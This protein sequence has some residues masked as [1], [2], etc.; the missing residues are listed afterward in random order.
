MV[1]IAVWQIFQCSPPQRESA[2]EGR[3][4][5]SD[6]LPIFLCRTSLPENRRKILRQELTDLAI[7]ATIP[8]SFVTQRYLL[9]LKIRKETLIE[10]WWAQPWPARFFVFL[11]FSV[12]RLFFIEFFYPVTLV[13]IVRFGAENTLFCLLIVFVFCLL[14]CCYNHYYRMTYQNH[15]DQLEKRATV[16][17]PIVLS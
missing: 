4:R 13:D 2:R 15:D 3:R 10:P 8:P 17:Q 5:S 1:V 6:P 9:E 11:F 16:L 7:V 14:Y 12:W